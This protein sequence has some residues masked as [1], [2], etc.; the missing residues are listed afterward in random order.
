MNHKNQ[1]TIAKNAAQGLKMSKYIVSANETDLFF[2]YREYHE[3]ITCKDCEYHRNGAGVCDI[4]HAY[5]NLNGYCHRARK[6][7]DKNETD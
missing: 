5:T 4:W 7:G 2:L 3:L 6:Y 1:P